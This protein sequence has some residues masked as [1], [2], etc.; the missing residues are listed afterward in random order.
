LSE[1]YGLTGEDTAAFRLPR[2]EREDV[3][4]L[5]GAAL[6]RRV[7]QRAMRTQQQHLVGHI[8]EHCFDAAATR[9][10]PTPSGGEIGLCDPCTGTD[11]EDAA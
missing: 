4:V 2:R 1:A 5:L 11:Q 9:I 6:R 8:C 10:V 3:R 7:E